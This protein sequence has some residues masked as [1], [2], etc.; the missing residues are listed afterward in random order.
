LSRHVNYFGDLLLFAGFAAITRQAWAGIVPIAMGLNFVFVI[1]PA[2]DAYLAARYG[3][4]FEA[5]AHR[6]KRLI[7]LLY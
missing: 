1:I 7:P 2:H 6:T 4:D 3:S 5:Y